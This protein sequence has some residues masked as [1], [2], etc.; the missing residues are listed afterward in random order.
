MRAMRR[1]LL[2][3]DVERWADGFLADLTGKDLT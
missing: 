3:H 1:Y 2:E